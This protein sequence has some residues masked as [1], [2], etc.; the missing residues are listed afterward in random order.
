LEI[1][2]A[3]FHGTIVINKFWGNPSGIS[4]V[5]KDHLGT[6]IIIQIETPDPSRGSLCSTTKRR[7]PPPPPPPLFQKM[8]LLPSLRIPRKISDGRTP[9]RFP[10][11][12]PRATAQFPFGVFRSYRSDRTYVCL[13][14]RHSEPVEVI[15]IT[16]L[17][18]DSIP[19]IPS[20]RVQISQDLNPIR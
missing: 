16:H 3:K 10:S 13:P 11:G 5:L 7:S 14:F 8:R 17:E 18:V 19:E 1:S 9:S 2:Y 12:F 6:P 15:L 4:S 20:V